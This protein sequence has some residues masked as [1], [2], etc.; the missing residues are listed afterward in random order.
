MYIC[1]L[2]SQVKRKRGRGGGLIGERGNQKRT[3]YLHNIYNNYCD[4]KD[5]KLRIQTQKRQGLDLYIVLLLGL[6]V[7]KGCC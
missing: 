2:C 5:Y 6:L 7:S 4:T 1:R 3:T